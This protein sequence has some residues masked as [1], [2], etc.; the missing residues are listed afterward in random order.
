MRLG[1]RGPATRQAVGQVA[2]VAGPTDGRRARWVRKDGLNQVV[3]H[4]LPAR[5]C[6]RRGGLKQVTA[7]FCPVPV[8][9]RSDAMGLDRAE[10]GRQPHRVVTGR[11]ARWVWIGLQRQVA[12]LLALCRLVSGRRLSSRSESRR[13]FLSGGC[14]TFPR[15]GCTGKSSTNHPRHE[16][17][18]L[19]RAKGGSG[20]N[21]R[22]Q[23][24]SV[25]E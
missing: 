19:D 12:S 13:H 16:I 20:L 8:G 23:R 9:F 14:G 4:T 2:G 5:G 21:Q 24:S 17:D 6:T 25:R 22:R 1:E 11:Q 15:C 18:R 10:T 3:N 7:P